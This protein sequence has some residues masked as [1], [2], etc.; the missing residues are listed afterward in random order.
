METVINA[1]LSVWL[2]V[3][4]GIGVFLAVKVWKN[5]KT[6]D[7]INI[8]CTIAIIVLVLHVIEEWVLPGGLHYSYNISHGSKDL[9]RYPMN[10]LTDMITN[11]GGVVL[12]CVVLK[13]WG[14]RKPAGIAVMLFSLFEVVIHIVIGITSLITFGKYGM[15]TIYSPGLITSLFG[16][17]PVAIGLAVHLFKKPNRASVKQW[18]M[19]V[20]AMFALCFLFINLPEMVLGDENSPYAFTDRGYYERYAEEFEAD[21]DYEYGEQDE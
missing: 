3:M 4:A 15:Q 16:F 20:V 18:I 12:G 13:I 8:L 14:F 5:R 19:A 10:R 21:N 1:W 17:L 11:F 7:T 9:A 6:W 2:Y